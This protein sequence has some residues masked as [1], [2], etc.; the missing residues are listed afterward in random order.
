MYILIALQ[1]LESHSFAET[2]AHDFK[3]GMAPFELQSDRKHKKEEEVIIVNSSLHDRESS[4]LTQRKKAS[5]D[6]ETSEGRSAQ[7]ERKA[8]WRR[9][10]LLIVAITV[11]NIPGMYVHHFM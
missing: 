3:N 10:L 6:V 4:G 2:L 7:D 5:L 11:H 8:S 1:G 9:I